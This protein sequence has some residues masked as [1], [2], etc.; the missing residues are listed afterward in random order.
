MD[1]DKISLK[2]KISQTLNN[3]N[4]SS[5]VFVEM[6]NDYNTLYKKYMNIQ[7]I[8]EQNQRLYSF[9]IKPEEVIKTDQTELEKKYNLIEE[10]YLKKKKENEKN[11]EEIKKKMKKKKKLI[12]YKK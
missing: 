1:P 9:Q 7:K 8:P 12:N 2:L 6:I 11:I 3:L 5:Q 10:Q 4:Q